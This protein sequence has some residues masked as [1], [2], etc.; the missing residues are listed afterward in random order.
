MEKR[1][2]P[3]TE[4]GWQHLI[5]GLVR[6]RQFELALIQF[7]KMEAASVSPSSWLLTLLISTFLSISAFPEVFVLLSM[8]VADATPS[9]PVPSILWSHVLSTAARAYSYPLVA[10]VWQRAVQT[11][12][13]NP[14]TGTCT[15]VLETAARF[16]DFKLATDVFRVLGKRSSSLAPYHYESL[17][18]SYLGANDL[19]TA[20]SVL[21]IMQSTPSP[22][23]DA[24]TRPLFLYLRARPSRCADALLILES[25]LNPDPSSVAPFT[26]PTIPVP[27]INAIIEAQVH[28]SDLPSALNTYSHITT[29]APAAG[30]TTFTFN[31]L[32]R[33]CSKLGRRDTA[34]FLAAEMRARG[35]APDALTYDR[36]MLTCLNGSARRD[37]ED[38]WRYW[39]ELRGRGWWARRGTVVLLARRSAEAGDER[40]WDLL[41]ES[42]GRGMDVLGVRRWVEQNWGGEALVRRA[43]GEGGVVHSV[44]DGSGDAVRSE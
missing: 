21:I 19:R 34:M 23:T 30:P 7:R 10:Y 13:L 12:Y 1:W 11:Q 3:L 41:S 40:V 29:L 9:R 8:R 16:G 31:V 28:A 36:L 5:A 39:A 22:P 20:L 24:T 43:R 6:D 26:V 25:R 35:V 27:A 44:S 32:L 15:A 38:A 2:F 4:Q 17:L 42:E 37:L 18:E 33:G 14:S